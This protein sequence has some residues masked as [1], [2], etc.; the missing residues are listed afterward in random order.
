M[1]KAKF[2]HVFI[3]STGRC[4]S[5]S[6]ARAC[7]HIQNYTS[8][9]ETRCTELGEE[10]FKYPQFH[11]ESDNRLSWLLGRLDETF[12]SDAFYLHLTRDRE[13]TA[14][15]YNR[16]WDNRYGIMPAYSRGILMHEPR[17]VADARDYYDTVNANIRLF[18]KDKPHQMSVE[19]LDLPNQFRTFC[20]K[21]GAECDIDLALRE[22]DKQHNQSAKPS[23]PRPIKRILGHVAKTRRFIKEIPAFYK[24][25]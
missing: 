16:R 24:I 12:G 23:P 7:E 22:W 21:I 19:M 17:G 15:S 9:H 5:M 2:N 25:S 8:G 10:R 11:I 20:E 3:L 6:F 13:E 1:T 4:G 14:Q 18:L